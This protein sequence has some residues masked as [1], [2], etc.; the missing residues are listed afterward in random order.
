M[1]LWLP[2]AS[3]GSKCVFVGTHDMLN[4]FSSPQTADLTAG[5]EACHIAVIKPSLQVMHN[6]RHRA[7]QLQLCCFYGT[8]AAAA[9]F[10]WIFSPKEMD[11]RI[12]TNW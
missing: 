10:H 1:L 6:L 3:S 12:S 2:S 9:A 4:G 7:L 8:A 5:D 11:K